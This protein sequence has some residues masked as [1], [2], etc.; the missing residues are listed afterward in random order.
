MS[1][2][3]EISF[4]CLTPLVASLSGRKKERSK[5]RKK[6]NLVPFGLV[7]SS[8]LFFLSLFL[9]FSFHFFLLYI[10]FL[11]FSLSLFL[12][13]FLVHSS[14]SPAFCVHAKV[15]VVQEWVNNH[16]S[17]F[18]VLREKYRSQFWLKSNKIWQVWLYSTS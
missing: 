7:H 12:S 4:F 16:L 5:E 6:S 2:C 18:V 17:E 10:F 11:Y 9:S 3:H 8:H 13:F 1:P 15:R 14:C